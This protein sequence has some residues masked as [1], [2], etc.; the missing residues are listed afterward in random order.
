MNGFSNVLPN[1][2]LLGN[3]SR[4]RELEALSLRV[5]VENDLNDEENEMEPGTKEREI[6][7]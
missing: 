5:S 2:F 4:I 3:E 1:P 6:I 7:I